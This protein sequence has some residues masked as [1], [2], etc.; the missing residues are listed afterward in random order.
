[1]ET[2]VLFA[3]I[4]LFLLVALILSIVG[5]II[6]KKIDRNYKNEIKKINKDNLWDAL[7]CDCDKCE[8]VKELNMYDEWKYGPYSILVWKPNMLNKSNKEY[9]ATL[10]Y[11]NDCV[12]SYSNRI[13]SEI[14]AENLNYIKAGLAR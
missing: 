3:I 8:L 9:L 6:S 12:L 2:K 14:L 13:K 11:K 4:C 7:I 5:L 1:M 10:F